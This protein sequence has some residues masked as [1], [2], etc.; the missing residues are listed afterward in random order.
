MNENS[1]IAEKLDELIFWTKF[2]ALPT[3]VGLLKN[4]LR[5][6]AEKLVYEFSDGEKSTRDI[7]SLL[8]K[9]G[10]KIT[11]ATVANMWQ[12]WALMW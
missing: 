2:S 1:L 8:S 10:I 4:E 12:R 7:A 3:F 5:S 9:T 6:D 11:H